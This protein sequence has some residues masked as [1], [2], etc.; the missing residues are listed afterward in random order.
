VVGVRQIGAVTALAPGAALCG[1][2]FGF[3]FSLWTAVRESRW[4]ILWLSAWSVVPLVWLVYFLLILH[5]S[6]MG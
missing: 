5:P 2:L 4:N 6:T 3:V 1:G